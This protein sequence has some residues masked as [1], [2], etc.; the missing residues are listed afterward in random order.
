VAQAIKGEDKPKKI[1]Q[2]RWQAV[3]NE[4]SGIIPAKGWSHASLY[5]LYILIGSYW[6]KLCPT[7][8]GKM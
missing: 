8:P 7:F 5:T 4:L 1:R 2:M 3:A 6:F